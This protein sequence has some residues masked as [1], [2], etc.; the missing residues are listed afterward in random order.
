MFKKILKKDKNEELERI[1]EEKKVDEQAKNLLQGIL[2]KIEVS[3]KDYQRSKGIEQTEEQYV[4][5][6]L[7]DIKQKCNRIKIVKISQKLN[8]EEIQNELKNKKFYISENE[9]ISYPIERKI[10]YAIEQNA[11]NNKI[12]NNQYGDA[13]I[14]VSDFINTGK[15][16]EEE[17]INRIW[18]RFYKVD[19]SRN[20]NDG[21]TGIG[22]SFVKAVMQN[23]KKGYGVVN[24]ENGVEFYIELELKI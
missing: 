5:Q 13:A 20:R 15:N 2:Y 3:Y 11:N 7:V 16:I 17:H 4:E 21:G 12:L 22:L 18:N 10:L 9:I 8:N 1:L 14:A 24:K 19:Q 23:Y 6:L